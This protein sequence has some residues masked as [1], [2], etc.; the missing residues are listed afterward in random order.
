L[1]HVYGWMVVARQTDVVS[2][3]TA[4]DDDGPP[5]WRSQPRRQAATNTKALT[6]IVYREREKAS[7]QLCQ[8][9]SFST[10]FSIRLHGRFAR[11]RLGHSTLSTVVCVCVWCWLLLVP[12]VGPTTALN[13]LMVSQRPCTQSPWPTVAERLV[14]SALW[15][16]YRI[17]PFPLR[18]RKEGPGYCN[19]GTPK[20]TPYWLA[21]Y[22]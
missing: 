4:R 8:V 16:H 11:A 15:L 17:P 10:S 9:G 18:R 19:T 6:L 20:S 3:C 14:G 1:V 5:G 2:Q 7:T 13:G 12:K 22:R 21:S